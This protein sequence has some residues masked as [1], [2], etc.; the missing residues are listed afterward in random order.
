MR[1]IYLDNNA[2]TRTAPEVLEAMKPYFSEI[3]GNASS[4]H[5]FGRAARAAVDSAREKVA[6]AIGAAEP[7]EIIF[8]S[9]GTES[10]NLAIKGTAWAHKEKGNHIITSAIEHH[11]V[12]NPCEFLERCGFEI[13]KL[14]V[15]NY[16]IVN[17]D[18][19]KRAITDKTILVTIMLANNEVGTIEPLEEVGAFCRERGV[20]FHTDAVQAVGKI[21]IDVQKLNVDLLSLSGHKFHGPKGVGALYMRK[22][23]KITP[24][25]HGGHHERS[26]RA[27]TENVPGIAGLAAAI[28]LA[29][30]DMKSKKEYL[31]NLRERLYNG[32][33]KNVDFVGLN[34]HPQKRL[35]NTLNVGFEFLEGES[36]VL[37]LD[38]EGVAASTGSACTSGS[39]EQSHVL[40]AMNVPPEKVQG[41]V[42][43]SL[44][45][46]NT[47]QEIDYVIEVLP[48]IVKRLRAMSPLYA[49]KLK[50]G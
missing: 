44:S 47:Q 11:A 16:G 40:G 18:A 13:T 43:F 20:L 23:T 2:T 34:G 38:L 48:P 31:T 50:K 27:G 26:M 25:L 35:V 22:R 17:L 14:P 46:E 32:I 7:S 6:Q 45:E 8:T 37:N 4:I 30:K 33:V 9:G 3:Y 21:S 12:L 19:L 15:D 39:L 36:I 24:L 42:R 28:E 29:G 49:D 10:D 1:K 41:A 5:T